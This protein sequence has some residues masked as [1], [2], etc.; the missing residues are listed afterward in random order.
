MKLVNRGER[1]ERKVV[2]VLIDKEQVKKGSKRKVLGASAAGL[3]EGS[4]RPQDWSD[5]AGRPPN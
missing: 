3:C 2:K 1:R 5:G 4:G